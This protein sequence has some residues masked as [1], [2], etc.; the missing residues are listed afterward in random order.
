MNSI[1]GTL[2]KMIR[3]VIHL[4]EIY[5]TCNVFRSLS[6]IKNQITKGYS[7]GNAMTK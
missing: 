6:S 4:Q 1:D 5:R 7:F 2:F 3:E